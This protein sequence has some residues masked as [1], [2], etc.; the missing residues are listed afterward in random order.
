VK[1]LTTNEQ[2]ERDA[3]RAQNEFFRDRLDSIASAADSLT[4][5]S[6]EMVEPLRQ[7][8]ATIAIRETRIYREVA[9]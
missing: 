2:R 6:P 3:E 7:Q 1:L 8:L 4:Y 5:A 9:R